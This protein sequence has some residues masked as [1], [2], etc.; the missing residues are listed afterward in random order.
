MGITP[1]LVI[2]VHSQLEIVEGN[3]MNLGFVYFGPD[4]FALDN[5]VG[6]LA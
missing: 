6:L 4:C 3:S 1:A 2:V 5:L